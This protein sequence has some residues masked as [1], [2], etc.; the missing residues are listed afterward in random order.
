MLTRQWVTASES[1]G[2][3]E[4]R[5][6]DDDERVLVR[7]TKDRGRGPV[8]SFTRGEWGDFL[9]GVRS[10]RKFDHPAWGAAG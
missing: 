3:V 7:D 10:S 5:L 9:R 4:V 2:C 6:A 8:L 1:G